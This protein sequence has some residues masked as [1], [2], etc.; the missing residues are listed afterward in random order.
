MSNQLSRKLSLLAL[1]LM[2]PIGVACLA[3]KNVTVKFSNEDAAAALR[4]VEQLSGVKIQYN[5]EDVK[6]K[7]TLTA[8]NQSPESVVNSIVGG[9]GLKAQS[10]GKYIIVSKAATSQQTAAGNRI[11]TGSVFDEYGDPLIGVSVQVT[12]HKTIG[13]PTDNDG[14][15]TLKN[16]PADAKSLTV[17]YIGM[18]TQVVKIGKGN[19]KITL[20]EDSKTIKE[21]VVNGYQQIDRRNL[22]SSTYTVDMDDIYVPGAAN[23]DQMLEGKIP[24]MVVNTNSGEINSTAR[25][26]VRGTSTLIG[27]REPLW[28]LDG[29]ILTDPISLSSDVLNDPDYV[30]RIGNAISGINPQDIDRIDVLKD[31]AATALY[32]TRA[33]NGV[34]V[35]TTKTGREGRPIVSYSG[36]GTFRARPRYTDRKVNLMNSNERIQFSQDL[37]DQHFT[38]P[39]SMPLV[40]YE[41]AVQ[42]LYNR[43]L[44]QEEFDAEVQKMAGR[45]TDWFK[46]LDHDSFSQDHSI[47]VSGGSDRI[48][49]YTSIGITD[50]DDVIK[51]T[52][53]RRYTAM[54]KI[55]I[56]LAKKFD[57]EF[58]ANGYVN[59]RMYT[60]GSV[61]PTN[62]AYNTSRTIPA[63]NED[64]SYSYYKKYAN[65]NAGYLNYSILNELDNSYS[66]QS[67]SSVMATLNMRYRPWDFLNFNWTTSV[68]T[69]SSNQ[70]TWYGEQSYYIGKLRYCEYG[71]TPPG[72]SLCPYGGELSTNNSRNTGWT[73]RL[74]ANYNKYLGKDNQHM[75]N[76]ALGVEL[77]ST[78]TKGYSRMDRM[79][80]ADRGETFMQGISTS[81][82]PNY[83]SDF[84]ASNVPTLVDGLNNIFSMYGTLTY[85]YKTLFTLNANARS[86]G[87]NRFG[88]R[89]NEKILPVWSVSGN[90][91]IIDIF[92][93]D[94]DWL[95]SLMLKSSYGEQGNMIDGQTPVMIIKKGSLNPVFKEFESSV[96]SFANP[97]LRWE[98]TRSFNVGLESSF[99]NN[100]V[101]IGAEYYYKKTTDAFM[102]KTISD[103]NGYTSYTIN[104]GTIINQGYNVT[105]S[106]TPIKLRDFYWIL[107]GNLSKVFNRVETAP[108]AESYEL[109][110]F[111]R[112]TAVV[113]GQ[114][115]G[116]FYS[117]KFAG[118]SPVDGGPLFYDNEEQEVDFNKLSNYDVYTKV[119]TPSGKR[120]HDVTGSFTNT[121]TYKR[122]RL[123][124][125][126]AYGLGAS[127]RL[128]RLFDDVYNGYN[129]EANVNRDLIDRWMQP[130]DEQHTNIPSLMG[131]GNPSYWYYSS[132]FS[133][134]YPYAGAVIADNAYEM[135]DY[136]DVRVVSANYLKIQML[137]L[138]YEFE[139]KLLDRLHLSRL[140]ITGSASNLYTFCDSKLRGQTPTQGGFTEVQ[141]SERPTFT[142]G[143]NVQ[144]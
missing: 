14:R 63:Y 4:K 9:H 17:S 19:L 142:L 140:A 91:N 87:S 107:S 26:R 40:G 33:A 123:G 72:N 106:F 127:T 111:L 100:R 94:N 23:L 129:A 24:D 52:T 133:S 115:I 93:I 50:Q 15:F 38:Y 98:K 61:N 83:F 7:V 90:A 68:N 62:Y 6:F 29:I 131:K 54:T 77:S 27:N 1:M 66:K 141:L 104:S 45:N 102:N 41:Y 138:T 120:E 81:D 46:I 126:C 108:G 48:R 116:T 5:F 139:K 118:L 70:E 49:Y 136:S 53:N 109:T 124:I 117:Y 73:T 128:F 56:K 122:W 59:D 39:S 76:V 105:W 44:T 132:H 80:F 42:Q 28:V 96:S 71:E 58:N 95:N 112:G 82:F 89:S 135:Y 125:S 143:L 114:P 32:G 16:V 21:F 121:F 22:T 11:V 47:N 64:G 10:N 69:A 99:F 113:E 79:Y 84:M 137:S 30:N 78:K 65:M 51:N 34:I 75:I 130:G 67:V 74:Q 119:L 18:K 57:V 85:A 134:G 101:Q 144:F 110:D 97:D 13:V 31:A 12:E 35:I 92:K 88:N 103:I 60:A 3:Q 43:Q 2:L 37:I 55:N 25:L 8:N 20:L 36:Q 86:D